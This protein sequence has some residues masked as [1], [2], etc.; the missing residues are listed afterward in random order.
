M[1]CSKGAQRDSLDDMRRE[2]QEHAN[3]FSRHLENYTAE[4][5]M[6]EEYLDGL[7][8]GLVE[9]GGFVRH[10]QLS[11]DQRSH[12]L[13]QERANLVLHNMRQKAPDNTDAPTVDLG[14]GPSSSSA[15]PS[16]A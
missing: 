7:H 12:M 4:V 15:R 1:S 3:S 10:N 9:Q 2:M 8:F 16:F 14:A 6:L 13:T 5:N 11:G